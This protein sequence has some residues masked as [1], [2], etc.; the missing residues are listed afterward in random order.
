MDDYGVAGENAVEDL[1]R[2]DPQSAPAGGV[3]S[4]SS[5]DCTNDGCTGSCVGC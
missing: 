4:Y 2:L 1:F 5:E 3:P